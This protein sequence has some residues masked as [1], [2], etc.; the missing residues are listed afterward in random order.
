M[1]D[2]T[3]Y[4]TPDGKFT[5]AVVPDHDL[6]GFEGYPWHT[7]GE[8]LPNVYRISSVP[9]FLNALFAD[10]LV[11]AVSRSGDT[12]HDVQV[13]DDPEGEKEWVKE[14]WTLELRYWSGRPY[15]AG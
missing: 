1:S 6:L 11:M 4:T 5:L 9:E 8:F 13:T 14:G 2:A 12:V 7:H 3:R 15:H 10:R